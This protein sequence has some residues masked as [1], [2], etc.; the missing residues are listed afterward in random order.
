MIA[1]VTGLVLLVGGYFFY[2]RVVTATVRPDPNRLTPAIALADGVDYVPMPTWRVYLI[3]LLNIAGLG[4]V[5]GPI[6]GALW[7]PQVFLWVV[8]GCIFGGAVHDLLT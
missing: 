2:G 5:F 6:L 4:P 1:F 7:G 3:Q 8:L